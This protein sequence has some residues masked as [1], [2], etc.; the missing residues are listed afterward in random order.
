MLDDA[1]D[2]G[3]IQQ[4]EL[5]HVGHTGPIRQHANH[6][7]SEFRFILLPSSGVHTVDDGNTNQRARAASS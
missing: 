2:T 3:T 5:E 6:F 1:H 7:I 4:H